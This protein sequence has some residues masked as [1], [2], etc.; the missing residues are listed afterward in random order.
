MR[1]PVLLALVP[2]LCFAKPLDGVP[3]KGA[4]AAAFAPKGWVVESSLEG[5]LNGDGVKDLVVVLLQ[6]DTSTDRYRAL[7]WLHGVASGGYVSVAS[8]VGL[9]ACLSCLGMKGGD[10]APEL[11]ISDKRVLSVSQWGGSRESYGTTHKFRLEKSGV[12]LIGLDSGDND[13]LT[14]AGNSISTNYLTGAQVAET[15]DEKGATKKVSKKLKLAPLPFAD[16][17]GYGAR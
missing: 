17:K 7:L 3:E 8:N 11:E 2:V 13:S 4:T 9:L 10:G 15:T 16:V 1:L 6:S 5:E 14:G 12:L